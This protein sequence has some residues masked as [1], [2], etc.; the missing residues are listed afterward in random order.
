[1][2]NME[3]KDNCGFGVIAD[4]KGRP[5][6]KMV[7]D[8]LTA[9]ERMMHRGAIAADGKSGDGS[10]LLFSMP[11]D[12]FKKVANEEGIDL[13]DNFGV[14]VIFL[15]N[16]EYKKTVEELCKKNDLNPIFWREVPINKEALGEFALKTL[17]KIY[18]LFITPN[19]IIATKRF[20]E[21]LY[22]TRKEI[23]K[24]IDDKDFYIPTFSSK[25]VAYKGLL[26]PNHIKEFYPDLADN[27]FKIYFAL[28][29]QRFSTNTLP[30]WRL[31]QPF[32]FIAH[33]GE[34]NSVQANRINSLIKSE[35]ITSK[36]YSDEELKRLLPIVRFDESDSSSLDRMMEFLIMN[37]MDFFKAVR[38]LIPM[39]WQNAPYLDSELKAF[40]EYFS[41]RFEAWDGPAA[42]SVSDGRYIAV[43]LD[44]NGLRPAKYV[45]TEDDKILI[46]SEY[47]VLD[48]ADSQKV[49][50]RGRLQSGQMI[51]IDT[52]FGIV[53]KNKDID[54]YLKSSNPYT[55]WL[56]EHMIYLQEYIENPYAIDEKIEIEDTVFKQ[57]YAGIT[58]ETIQ[59]MIKPM[60]EDAKEPTGSMGDDTPL[61]CFS[62]YAFR[63]FNDFFRQKFAQVTNPPIDPLREKIVMSLNTGFGEIH[64]ILD[65]APEHAK[66]IKTTTPILTQT[67]LEVLKS[68]GDENS[69]R[70]ESDYKNASYSITYTGELKQALE[71]LTDKIVEDV[72]NGVRI[73][74]LNDYDLNRNTKSMPMAMVVGRL[75]KKLLENK[76]RHLTSIVTETSEVITPHDAAV[77]IAYGA[78]AIYPYLLFKTV[79][80]LCDDMNIPRDDALFNVHSALNKGILKIISKMGISTIASYRN[81][82]LFDIIGLSNEV[83]AECFEGSKVL[84]PGLTYKDIDQKITKKHQEA[85]KDEKLAPGGVYKYKKGEEDHE[86]TP[87][88]VKA[89]AKMLEGGKEEYN[90]FKKLVENRHPTYI[91]DFLEIKSDRK[92]IDINKV[93][94]KENIIKRFIGAAMSIGALSKESHEILAEALNRLGARSNSGE[95]GE[96]PSRN[97]TIKQSKIRQVASGRFGV[98]PEYLVNAEEIQIKVAQGAKPGEGGQLPGFKVTTYIAKLRHTTPGKTLISPPPHHDIY[99]IE[100]LAQLIFDLKQINPQAKVS[101]KLV[102]TAGVGTIAAGVAKAYADH[103]VIS[104][105]EG[106]TGAAAITS[107]KHAGNPWEL[108]LVE[109]HNSLKANHLR[110]FVSLETDGA[111]KVGRDVIFA[112]L[113]GAEYYAFGTALLM[114]ERCIFCRSCQTNKCPVGITTQDE[115]F[116]A[117]FKGAVEKV[118]NYITLL[119]ED[120]R[121]YLAQMGYTSIDEIIGRN[122]LITL[123]DIDLAKKFDFSKLFERVE[124]IETKQKE[125]IPFDKN[126]FE[127]ELLKS[128][129]DTIKNPNHKS[130]VKAK[131]NNLNRS[132]GALTS[133]VIAKYYGDKGL[134]EESI[135]YKLQGIAGQSFGVFLSRG[136]TLMLRGVANDYV[137]KGMA[138]GKIIITP[139]KEGAAAGNTCLYGATGGK[140]F[141]AGMVGERFGVRNSGAIAV[142]EGCG[143]HPCE[144]MTGGEVIILGKTGINFGAGMTGGV[145]FVYDKE[146]DFVDKINPELIEIRRIDIDENEKPK[147]YLK[148]RLIEYYNAT[149]SKKAKEILDNFRSEVRHFWLVTPKDN[150]PPL[151]PNDMD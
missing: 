67:K 76:L 50:E 73:I 39:P 111:L 151:D 68:F 26:M 124:G 6:H 38:S 127:K 61:A 9:L 142:I 139:H 65:E 1:M 71:T 104:G 141:V 37:G 133:G 29:H 7:E 44:R 86:I 49:K 74:F 18:H 52:K 96:D 24:A 89:F 2:S 117:K 137:G 70:F 113:F 128:V 8:A 35:S 114:A 4:V 80:Q 122:D 130:V 3:F 97:K 46:A 102:S 83:S 77:M 42:V 28:F 112:A 41:T 22:L 147:I 148:K 94:S 64:N 107:I 69:P 120:V 40:Y 31:A 82:A 108:G 143:D 72:K 109:A 95:G 93:E 131:I 51:G 88:V 116:R 17:P 12:F 125:N 55:K 134:P 149:G 10:G 92:P 115:N 58:K 81:S 140:L 100:D 23:E 54:E 30:E 103:I 15:K 11:K 56:N 32:R 145:A 43:V 118:M 34:I 129:M 132:F 101:V 45:I 16:E 20:E 5:T 85:A 66:R 19:S 136:M 144:Y 53:L 48:I 106:G 79:C 47:G 110:E 13:P 63:S 98:T 78:T 60:I 27:D 90:E 84:L 25:K 138:G 126:E 62:D 121:E 36:V 57:R 123:K 105:S 146:H 59:F 87:N 33:N 91:R 119:A 14:G 99:S 135:V 21:L 75:H 150:R